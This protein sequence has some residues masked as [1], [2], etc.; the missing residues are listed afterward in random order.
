MTK[1]RYG[2]LVSIVAVAVVLG[3]AVG[4]GAEKKSSDKYATYQS[5]KDQFSV[6]VP[7]AFKDFKTESQILD[8]KLGKK[9]FNVYKSMSST[10]GYLITVIDF[11]LANM[12]PAEIKNMLELGRAKVAARGKVISSDETKI[13]GN[14][15]L[16]MRD[17]MSAKG[18]DIYSDTAFLY[19]GGRQYQMSVM[20]TSAKTLDSDDVKRF[21]SSF[22][23][24]GKKK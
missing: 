1:T 21:F 19:V 9:S 17:K 13:D 8:T 23:Y 4:L 3:S 11:G 6:Q 22:K 15:A 14:M 10:V 5:A 20:A 16:K 2:I 18:Q 7:I 24:T 12:K